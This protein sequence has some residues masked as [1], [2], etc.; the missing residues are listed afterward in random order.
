MSFLVKFPI[1]RAAEPFFCFF[2]GSSTAQIGVEF[3]TKIISLGN[4][5]IKLQS[6]T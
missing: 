1:C 2:G 4:R 5:Q 6:Q 3:G